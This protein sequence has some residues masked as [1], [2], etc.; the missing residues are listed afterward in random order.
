MS[1]INGFWILIISL[2]LLLPIGTVYVF[3]QRARLVPI[4]KISKTWYCL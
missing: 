3:K 4:P 1:E 2:V